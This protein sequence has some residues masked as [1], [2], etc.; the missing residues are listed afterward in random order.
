MAMGIIFF[1]ES[2]PK[3]FAMVGESQ[4]LD[5][6]L[7]VGS[8]TIYLVLMESRWGCYD[9]PLLY[10]P[11]ESGPLIPAAGQSWADDLRQRRTHMVLNWGKKEMTEAP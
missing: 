2:L 1:L 7:H 3:F 9:S 11:T 6:L 4:G 8:G 5:P 10:R